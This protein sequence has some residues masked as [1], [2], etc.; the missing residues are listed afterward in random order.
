M[1]YVWHVREVRV[2]PLQSCNKP[3][4]FLTT[5]IF[6][7][8]RRKIQAKKDSLCFVQ[9]EE[10]ARL[11]CGSTT[12]KTREKVYDNLSFIFDASL[13]YFISEFFPVIISHAH[14]FRT[15]I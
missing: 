7:I 11:R 14:C 1:I 12:S 15:L 8:W 10:I 5:L 2:P 6:R 4:T 3:Q 9:S 13:F